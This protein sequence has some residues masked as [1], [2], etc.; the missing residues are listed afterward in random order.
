MISP[1]ETTYCLLDVKTP[2]KTPPA[3]GSTA[4]RE[5]F[6]AAARRAFKGML[7]RGPNQPAQYHR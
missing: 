7:W 5:S 3:A 4:S 1:P 6:R 2:I